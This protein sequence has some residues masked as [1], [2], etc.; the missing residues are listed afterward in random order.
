M[1]HVKK[2]LLL[3]PPLHLYFMK[4]YERHIRMSEITAKDKAHVT[5]ILSPCSVFVA[6]L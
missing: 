4:S 1:N 3:F 6:E 5:E 2:P